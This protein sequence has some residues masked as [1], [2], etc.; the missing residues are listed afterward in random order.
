MWEFVTLYN[1]SSK[2]KK[3]NAYNFMNKEAQGLSN[4]MF[5]TGSWSAG[6]ITYT[7]NCNRSFRLVRA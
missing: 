1:S 2:E 6:G 4:V 7:K 5:K 3:T